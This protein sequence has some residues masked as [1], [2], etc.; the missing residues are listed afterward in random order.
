M[1]T[2]FF[3]FV[4]CCRRQ[5]PI[6]QQPALPQSTT[7]A[8]VSGAGML[9]VADVTGGPGGML[10]LTEQESSELIKD[11]STDMYI[12]KISCELTPEQISNSPVYKAILQA[13]ANPQANIQM[14]PRPSPL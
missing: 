11:I 14:S 8:Y 5:Q 7:V 1:L 6:I 13:R 10:Q 4:C 3:D 12:G 2:A 9:F